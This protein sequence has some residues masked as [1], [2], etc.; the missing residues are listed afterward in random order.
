M[1]ESSGLSRLY[2]SL[3]FAAAAIFEEELPKRLF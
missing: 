3:F 2:G 1:A